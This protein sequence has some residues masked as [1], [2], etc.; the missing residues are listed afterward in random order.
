MGNCIILPQV[1]VFYCGAP[2][3]ADVIQPLCDK[4]EFGFKK[5]IFQKKHNSKFE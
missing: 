4:F 2:Q 5:E 1:T 3:A